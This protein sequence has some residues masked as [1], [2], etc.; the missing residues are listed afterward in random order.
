MV[1][2]AQ[3]Y[4]ATALYAIRDQ[5]AWFSPQTGSGSALLTADIPWFGGTGIATGKGGGSLGGARGLMELTACP[6][7]VG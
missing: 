2:S 3:T 5:I 7:A 1:L 4:L 6:T